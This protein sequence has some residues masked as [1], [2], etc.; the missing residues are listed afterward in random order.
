MRDG[1]SHTACSSERRAV[2]LCS[3]LCARRFLSQQPP[4]VWL[5]NRVVVEVHDEKSMSAEI[6]GMEKALLEGAGAR[7]R[8]DLSRGVVR[9][10]HIY[11]HTV[12]RVSMRT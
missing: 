4:A 7:R 1:V 11:I 5:A 2:P 6:V 12:N 9:Y 8:A 3:A 10:P